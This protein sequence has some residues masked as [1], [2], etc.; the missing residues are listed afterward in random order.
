MNDLR[1]FNSEQFGEIRGVE[2]DGVPWLVGK[3]VAV[4]LGYE[5]PTDAVRKHVDEE[6]RGVSKMETPSGE[7]NM[8]IINESGLYSLVLSSKLP[9]ARQFRR[10]VISEVL[11]S[12]R[13]HG[14]YIA[15]QET[16]TDA[17]L[18][19][20]AVLVAQK[21][22]AERDARISALEVQ[23]KLDAP[24]VLFASAV[25]TAKS[26]IL[27]SV[28]A[29]LLKQNGVQN[30]GQNRLFS[31]MRDNEYLIKRKGSDYNMP[32][33]KAMELGL[34]EIKETAINNPDGSVRVTKTP[35][36]TGKGQ[37]YFIQKFLGAD[38]DQAE[39]AVE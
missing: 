6:D 18:M 37:I 21:T 25:E 13:K 28:M 36:V 38:P 29:K 22:I 24:K 19:A 14:G 26:S 3:D 11:P 12:I 16:M 35:K 31:W 30:M 2:I 20:K 39:E 4:A 23:V 15:G 34:F 10:W 17:E 32:T 1:I 27:V 7:Q 33:Q 8:T 9:T 5:K